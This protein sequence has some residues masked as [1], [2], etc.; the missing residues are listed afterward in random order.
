MFCYGLLYFKDIL[1]LELRTQCRN[2]LI[3]KKFLYFKASCYAALSLMR[4]AYKIVRM[5]MFT[6]FVVLLANDVMFLLKQP[7]LEDGL[8][9]TTSSERV[10]E[11]D[12]W[13]SA[14]SQT[15]NVK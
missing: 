3:D 13:E 10:I 4:N 12:S 6:P 14:K 9:T 5:R 11:K 7:V 15:Q 2:S 1:R 8:T